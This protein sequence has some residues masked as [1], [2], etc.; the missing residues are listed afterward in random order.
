MMLPTHSLSFINFHITELYVHSSSF[1][2]HRRAGAFAARSRRFMSCNE[3]T[4][5]SYSSQ[6]AERAIPGVAE[7]DFFEYWREDGY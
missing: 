4:E 3:D 1:Q 2:C 7:Q 5:I 6:S